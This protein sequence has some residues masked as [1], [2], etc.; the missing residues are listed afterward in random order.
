MKNKSI[1][2]LGIT[3]EELYEAKKQ[4]NIHFSNKP[5]VFHLVL[6]DRHGIDCK[7]SSFGA[8]L[9]ARTN[10]G[11]ESKKY[12]RIED[13]Q[14]AVRKLINSKVETDNSTVYYS[15][16]KEVYTF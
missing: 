5:F 14:R 13:L 10:K 1:T 7:I 11:L 9:W 16:S 6:K 8:N 12:N 3:I 15:L 2:E 4:I